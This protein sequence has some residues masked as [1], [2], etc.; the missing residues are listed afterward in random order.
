MKKL[1]SLILSI[2]MLFTM[3][4]PAFA[5]YE[6]LDDAALANLTT[7]LINIGSGNEAYTGS[8][9]KLAKDLVLAD[10]TPD[11][12]LFKIDSSVKTEGGVADTKSYILLKNVNAGENDGYFVMVAD[13]APTTNSAQSAA[14]ALANIYP[15]I[16][17]STNEDKLPNRYFSADDDTSIAYYLNT[18]NYI[19]SH[20]PIMNEGN[21]INDHTWYTEATKEAVGHLA[22]KTTCKIALPSVTEWTQNY[23]R[24]GVKTNS[25]SH[26][27]SRFVTRTPHPNK[28]VEFVTYN[29]NKY[30][31][32]GIWLITTAG[33][34]GN[35]IT[36]HWEC[37][38]RPCFYLN[39]DFFKNVK[40][41]MTLLKSEDNVVADIL[42]D[43][44]STE[45]GKA[46]LLETYTVSELVEIGIAAGNVEI[47]SATITG[48]GECDKTLVAKV[49]TKGEATTTEYEWIK[50]A[51]DGTET[52]LD[53]VAN[54]YKVKFADLGASIKCFVKV[55]E[56]E[57]L[58]HSAYTNTVATEKAP[59][60]EAYSNLTGVGVENTPEAYKFTHNQIE[61]ILLQSVNADEDDGQ[62]V[63]LEEPIS[64][65]NIVWYKNM[66]TNT[67]FIYDP[68][69]PNSIAAQI[70]E[71]AFYNSVISNEM[72]PYVNT[73]RWWNEPLT[74]CTSNGVDKES[75]YYNAW[76][77][78]SKLAILS[79]TEYVKNA[80]R[81]GYSTDSTID[82]L[83]RTPNF[84]WNGPQLGIPRLLLLSTKEDADTVWSEGNQR[85][86]TYHNTPPNTY[87]G[88]YLK[89][90][91]FYL[92]PDFFA[93][94]AVDF[95][96]ENTEVIA[97]LREKLAGKT[98]VELI[99]MGYSYSDIKILFPALVSDINDVE[100]Y[101][102]TATAGENGD[103]TITYMCENTTDAP[104]TF[105]PLAA[106][107]ADLSLVD[108]YLASESIT[109]DKGVPKMASFTINIGTKT[110]SEILIKT[111]VW[112][113]EEVMPI[114]PCA[115][116]YLA[117]L[118]NEP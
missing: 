80:D 4:T 86:S 24:M 91:S 10:L 74:A 55:Y 37:Q 71:Q 114:A 56:G 107:Y 73:H 100:M 53:S 50:V 64:N 76:A 83:L 93:N 52:I 19:S 66:D 103:Y 44:A 16:V 105:K 112:N 62:F 48:T 21:Y 33:F 101:D 96:E 35:A 58:V 23:E 60:F 87:G 81:I 46:A 43:I 45:E 108:S 106:A 98:K 118:G 57:T 85:V 95:T 78:E 110:A 82:T 15:G 63:T 75:K 31:S 111:F 41:D 109:L 67:T 49:V 26:N 29:S 104:V 69:D 102:F 97:I 47:T 72:N 117:T 39:E 115:D 65:S 94:V 84:S 2:L 70:N 12:Y 6:T 3:V 36:Y 79:F 11:K 68:E 17:I 18:E 25:Y 34:N 30:K 90:V 1:L 116:V 9:G 88:Y 77:T 5:A 42:A 13:G 40:L 59:V 22:S 51:A 38:E 99:D 92:N 8:A 89:P 113:I 20:F 7:P 32:Y 27:P 14:K 28:E 54:S 61:Y